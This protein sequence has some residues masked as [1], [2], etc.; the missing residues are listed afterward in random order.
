M[1]YVEIE[2]HKERA[3]EAAAENTEGKET[4]QTREEERLIRRRHDL[5]PSLR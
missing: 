1:S 4:G 3:E 2:R 5:C